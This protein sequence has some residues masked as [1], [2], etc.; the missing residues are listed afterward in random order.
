MDQLAEMRVFVRAIER[1][2]FAVAAKD[3]GLT[4]SAVSKLIRRLETR[5]GVRLV[6]RTTRKLALTAEG[7]TYFHSGRQLI[8]AID[9]LEHEVAA[10]AAH[11]RGLLR[12]NTTVSFGVQ[13]LSPALMEFQRRYPDVRVSIS[14]TDRPVD[15]HAQQIDVAVR[16][17]PLSD[18]SLMSR[19]VGEVG[20]VICASP[21]YLKQFGTPKSRDD[22]AQHRCIVFTAPGRSRWAFRTAD[23]GVEHVDVSGVFA[24]DSQECVLQLALQGAGIARLA[25]FMV[26]RPIRDGKLVPLL[27]DQHHPERTPAYAVFPPGTQ[28]IPKVRVF[29]DFLVERFRSQ[30]QRAANADPYH[31]GVVALLW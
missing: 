8:E 3:L 18:S 19:K 4:P 13:H 6:N 17:G 26:A 20:R 10:S 28:K 22:L 12:I 1:G 25:D 31:V 2:T 30:P 27:A 21:Q 11:P 5:L 7:E 9:G 24:S 15:L 29:L 23:G 14:L 16:V